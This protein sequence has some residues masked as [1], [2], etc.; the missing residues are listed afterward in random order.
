MKVLCATSWGTAC[1]I[2][3]YAEQARKWIQSADRGIAIEC[4][5]EALDPDWALGRLGDVDWLWLNHHDGLHSRWEPGHVDE[6]HK[7]SCKV[8]VTY[9]DTFDGQFRPNSDKAKT[10][11][12]LADGFVVH[13]PV[14]DLH[15]AIYLRQ[16]VH[17]GMPPR[18]T[19]RSAL[20]DAGFLAYPQQPILASVGFNFPWKN[21]D[22]VA[23]VSAEC[24]WALLLLVNNAT[25]AD[26]TRWRS[27]N[28]NLSVI[29]G[30]LP[31]EE[32]V[33]YLASAD[34]TVFAYECA[35]AGTSGAI[36]QGI[37]ARKPL[38]AWKGCRQF[39]DLWED[40][41]HHSAI[42][43]CPSFGELPYYLSEI[44]VGPVDP[45]IVEIATRDAWPKQ[46]RRYAEILRGGR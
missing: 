39:R 6:A 34:A 26:E 5:S 44:T 2:A 11:C 37:A 45:G 14:T 32:A 4:R 17:P 13:E 1:G 23:Q 22:R 41:D 31:Q 36:R 40:R 12:S 29:T 8:L 3:D 35:N 33:S 46:G 21:F 43:W 38:I 19:D 25:G 15:E 20:V 30:F 28:P 9:H 7:R 42:S 24:G 16:G 18:W 10:L 27:F